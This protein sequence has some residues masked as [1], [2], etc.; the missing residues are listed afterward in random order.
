VLNG[1][2]CLVNSALDTFHSFRFTYVTFAIRVTVYTETKTHR[3]TLKR[4]GWAGFLMLLDWQLRNT[5]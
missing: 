4:R 2:K 5:S 1:H 3:N